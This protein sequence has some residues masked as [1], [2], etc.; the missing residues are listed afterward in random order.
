VRL[1]IATCRRSIVGGVE[2]YLQTVIPALSRRGHDISILYEH[3]SEPG[4][5]TVDL[6]GSTLPLWYWDHGRDSQTL[7]SRVRQWNPDVVYAHGYVSNELESLVLDTAPAV[8]YG[9]VYQGTCISGRKCHA[10]GHIQPCER[11]FGVACLALYYPCRCGGL[12]PLRA[13]TMYQSQ[14]RRNQCL[15]GYRAILVASSHMREEFERNGID[16]SKLH[17]V[18]LPVNGYTPQAAPPV[19]RTPEGRVLF[20]GRLTD[21]KGVGNLI[22]AIPRASKLLNRPLSLSVAGEGPQRR[23]LEDLSMRLGVGAS[24]LAWV[25]AQRREELMRAADLLAVPS[26][27]PEPF[28][29]V[30]MEA[31]CFGLPAV[32]YAV[33]GIPDWLIAGQTGEL[34]P[35]NPPTVEGLAEAMVRALA[36]DEHYAKLSRGAWELSK[37]FNMERHLALLE[38][39]LSAAAS[40]PPMASGTSVEYAMT[41]EKSDE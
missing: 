26:L 28:G 7:R 9:H 14:A 30:G 36:G 34:A 6:P 18:P 4:E 17:L 35:G 31:G 29:L 15:A 32:G 11:R 40:L 3:A 38:P 5:E 12:N 24:F 22:E 21:L 33:G 13:W 20:I 10:A 27:W 25:D 1:L 37:R 8:Q 39:I 23:K 41:R 2:K 16:P 19:P